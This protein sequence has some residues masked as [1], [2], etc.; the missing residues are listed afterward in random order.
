MELAKL[1]EKQFNRTISIMETTTSP[2]VLV[3]GASGFIGSHTVK[4]LLKRGYRV[5]GTVRDPD[6]EGKVAHLKKI[7]NDARDLELVQADLLDP[8]EKWVAIVS[9]CDYVLHIASPL[10]AEE[11]NDPNMIIQPA[12]A[13][14]K[15]VYNAC[16]EAKSVKRLVVTGSTRSVNEGYT[17]EFCNE[18]VF[19]EEDWSKVELLTSSYAKSK[20]I[21]EQALWDLRKQ[22]DHQKLELVVLLPVLVLGPLL[23]NSVN[24]SAEIIRQLMLR[25]VPGV[26]DIQFP[27][28]DVREVAEAEVLALTAENAV[29]KRIILCTGHMH[30]K[31]IALALLDEFGPMGYNI[32]TTQIPYFVLYMGS[33]LDKKLKSI[34]PFVG[35]RNKISNQRAK[36]ILNMNFDRLLVDTVLEMAHSLVENN[37]V[38]KQPGYHPYKT[39]PY[40]RR[41]G[42]NPPVVI[43]SIPVGEKIPGEDL[44]RRHFFAKDKLFGPPE[45]LV[46]LGDVLRKGVEKFGD[47]PCLG[48]RNLIKM[49]NEEVDVNGTTKTWQY[50]ELSPYEWFTYSE[51]Y[52]QVRTMANG[53]RAVGLEPGMRLG[54]YEDTRH[55][56]TIAAHA[57]FSQCIVAVTVYANLGLEGLTVAL[58]EG[59]LT[60]VLTNGNL[61]KSLLDVH[62]NIPSVKTV[63]YVDEANA[64]AKKSLEE[65]GIRVISYEEVMKLGA[66]EGNAHEVCEGSPDD[67]AVI[68]YTSGSTGAP[69][70]V[71]IT[72]RN[73][74]SFVN[75][76]TPLVEFNETDVYISY[77]P[78][79]H[80]LALASEIL[81][82]AVGVAVGHANPRTLLD[83]TVRNCAGDLAALRPTIM[84]GVPTVWDRIRKGA[85]AKVE[86]GSPFKQKL[87]WR[88][89]AAKAEAIK[90]GKQT[91]LYDALVFSKF[92]SVVGGRLRMMVS[93]GA[94][95]SET[96]HTFL[97]VC[98]GIPV[99]QGYGLTETCG[100]G[101]IQ[102][103]GE[104]SCCRSGAPVPCCEI[105]LVDVP[106]LNYLSSDK[107][108]PRGEI[109]IKGDNV[110]PGYFLN[111]EKTAE[112]FVDG[113]FH[114]GDIGQWCE[115]GTLAIIDRKKNLVKLSHGE[116]IALE[117]LESIYKACKYVD[118]VMVYADSH[119]TYPIA[120]VYPSKERA[121]EW[122]KEAGVDDEFTSLCHNKDFTAVVL[123]DMVATGRAAGLKSFEIVKGVCLC[124][125]E[126]TPENELLTAAMKLKRI[127]LSEKY[128]VELDATYQQTQ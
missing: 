54:I 57:C 111:D 55:E 70:G 92:Q 102:V 22:S 77:L 1:P 101:T 26:P 84:A 43:R 10:P 80:V 60:H 62:E 44:P 110:S 41:I 59:K 72:S 117:R 45:D 65:C 89:Y 115:D 17:Q 51:V 31:D 76:L 116:Y 74:L 21:A 16:L 96:T 83:T 88:A 109:C 11:A 39:R 14:T 91:P 23:Q 106:E 81:T 42:P 40:L 2:L 79:A 114:T 94:P 27:I 75:A 56:W 124:S 46:V 63:I 123:K 73:I 86:K 52:E 29:D 8:L 12:V 3:T 18:H 99:L 71:L 97:R 85:L 6:N 104:V 13:G 53:L 93:G 100:G 58:N 128:K 108:H 34:L 50:P 47:R 7:S 122:A 113:W 24:A 87:F 105:K 48:R 35:V 36:D 119:K 107:P 90:Q 69:K 38:P 121:E 66:E 25:M 19:T 68:M 20:V 126:W 49:H 118:N 78:L 127:P 33:F 103:P 125:E 82:L 95:L 112:D 9:G 64:E 120:L 61:L 67:V 5:R 30:F 15:N 37:M 28:V 4:A 98:F 32:P